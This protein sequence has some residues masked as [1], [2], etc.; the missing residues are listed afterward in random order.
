MANTIKRIVRAL[1]RRLDLD[2]LSAAELDFLRSQTIPKDRVALLADLPV[3]DLPQMLQALIA[4]RAQLGQD[5]MVL[6]FLAFKRDGYFVEF[7]ATNGRELSN[8]WL[9]ETGYGWSGI[10]AE[11]ARCWHQDLRANRSARIDT[12]CVWTTS[13]QRLSFHETPWAEVSTLTAYR[14]ADAHRMSRQ[15]GRTYDVTT[16]SLA[17]LLQSHGAPTRI[18]YL[19]IDTEGSEY[20]ILAAHD[21]RRFHFDVITVEHNRMPARDRIHDLLTSHGYRRVLEAHSRYDDWY[22]SS[23]VPVRTPSP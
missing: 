15:K 7:G 23:A 14:D 10:L 20:D 22:L 9:L 18:D 5:L 3:T 16:V 2:V 17:D 8:T 19:S 13:G 1:L 4:S 21:F 11:P 6:A 12:R